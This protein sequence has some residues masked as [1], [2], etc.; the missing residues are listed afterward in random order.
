MVPKDSITCV[1][2]QSPSKQMVVFPSQMYIDNIKRMI[3][4]SIARDK[5]EAEIKHLSIK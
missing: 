5:R 1:K 3:A 2:K 4:D